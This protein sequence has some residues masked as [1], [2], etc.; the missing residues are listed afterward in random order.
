MTTHKEVL[1]LA[2]EALE[3]HKAYGTTYPADH[4]AITAIKEAL[5]TKCVAQPAVVEPHKQEPVAAIQHWCTYCQG[6]NIHNCQFN[7]QLPR[8]HTYTTNNTATSQGV[9]DDKTK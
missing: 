2:L 8:F 7:M 9:K 4:E 6:H 5:S 1:T 3:K